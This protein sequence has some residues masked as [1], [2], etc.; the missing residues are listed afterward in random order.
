VD[1]DLGELDPADA[2]G[3]LRLDRRAER[4]A[5]AAPGGPE[6]D[7]DRQLVRALDHVALEGVCRDVHLELSPPGGVRSTNQRNNDLLV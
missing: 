2:L 5:R 6:V 1:V 7:D 3:D 4:P